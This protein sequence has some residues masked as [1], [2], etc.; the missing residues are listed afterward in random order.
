MTEK[1]STITKIKGWRYWKKE[2]TIK[3]WKIVGLILLAFTLGGT[4]YSDKQS[5]SYCS[6]SRNTVDTIERLVSNSNLQKEANTKT[7]NT[8]I[9][10]EE[11]EQATNEREPIKLTGTGQQA[12]E[13]FELTKGLRRF[14]MTHSGNSHFGIWLMDSEGNNIELLVNEVGSF[15]GSKAVKINQTGEYLLDVSADGNWTVEIE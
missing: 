5:T 1:E 3:E 14:E 10:K 15:D 9:K 13:S 4:F 11:N 2:R 12:T 8:P 7:D 6:I